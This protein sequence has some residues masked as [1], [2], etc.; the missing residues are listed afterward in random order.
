[1][2][3]CIARFLFLMP[4]T[5]PSL[6]LSLCHNQLHFFSLFSPFPFSFSPYPLSLPLPAFLPSPI[7]L[8]SY[9]S[10]YYTVQKYILTIKSPFPKNYLSNITVTST[11]FLSE[12]NTGAGIS[13][14]GFLLFLVYLRLLPSSS[15]CYTYTRIFQHIGR[16]F[17]SKFAP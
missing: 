12:V 4:L 9:S 13:F 1:M 8:S 6:P 16:T 7:H 15:S 2:Y 5:G 11:G 14:S 10:P 3:F 17:I